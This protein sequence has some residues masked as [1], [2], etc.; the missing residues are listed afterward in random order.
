MN[1]RPERGSTPDRGPIF[2]LRVRWRTG[3]AILAAAA[4]MAVL[5]LL[6]P[7]A[8]GASPRLRL[9]VTLILGLGVAASALLSSLRSRGTSEQIAFYVFLV[10]CLDGLGQILGPLGWPVWPLLTL[11]IGAVAVAEPPS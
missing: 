11:L 1:E 6:R 9:M 2:D 5:D 7:L 10:L 8:P 4:V 3:Q